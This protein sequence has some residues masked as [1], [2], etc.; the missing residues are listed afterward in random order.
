MLEECFVEEITW[1]LRGTGSANIARFWF[2][3]W[4]GGGPWLVASISCLWWVVCL[5]TSNMASVSCL[6]TLPPLEVGT[7]NGFFIHLFLGFFPKLYIY[8][9]V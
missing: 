2:L 1:R 7:F 9:G 5:V 8:M 4:C 6:R 3:W